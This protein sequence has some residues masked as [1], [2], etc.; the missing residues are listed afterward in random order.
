MRDFI[1]DR[2]DINAEPAAVWNILH[3]FESYPEWRGSVTTAEVV[4][5]DA[6]RPREVRFGAHVGPWLS[7][8]TVSYAYDSDALA[9]TLVEGD[10]LSRYDGYWATTPLITGRTRVEL[11]L[12]VTPSMPAPNFIVQQATRQDLRTTLE[13]LRGRATVTKR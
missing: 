4:S 13:E 5:N 10:L 6:T 12:R 8:Y 11:R 7:H 1:S 2:I 3:D 9:W